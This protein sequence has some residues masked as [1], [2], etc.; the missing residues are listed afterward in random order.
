LTRGQPQSAV[1]SRPGPYGWALLDSEGW[2]AVTADRIAIAAGVGK[3]TI[4]RWWR[5][6]ADVVLEALLDRARAQ[7]PP[8]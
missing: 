2:Q 7:V 1:R 6:K 3:Q 8:R 5:G 4:Y